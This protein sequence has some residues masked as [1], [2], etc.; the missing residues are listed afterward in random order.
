MNREHVAVDGTHDG[1][2]V[3]DER[4]ARSTAQQALVRGAGVVSSMVGASLASQAGIIHVV[5][6]NREMGFV[7]FG[8]G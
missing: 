3:W 8:W 2:L 7:C 6:D 4:S 1:P 5:V